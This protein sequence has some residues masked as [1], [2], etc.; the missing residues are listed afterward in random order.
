MSQS[1]PA[2][3]ADLIERVC[4]DH[5]RRPPM[6]TWWQRDDWRSSGTTYKAEGRIH[7]TAGTSE[8]DARLV[9][10]HELAHWLG[11]PGWHHRRPFWELVWR[12]Y[13]RYG[14]DLDWAIFREATYVAKSLTYCPFVA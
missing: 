8:E 3:A 6:V 5:G 13:E 9:L 10:L 14:V 2:W 1:P 4:A 12:L 11:R 7:V